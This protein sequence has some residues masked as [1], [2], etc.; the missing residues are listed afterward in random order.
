MAKSELQGNEADQIAVV[1]DFNRFYTARLGLLRKR[2]LDGE[3]SLT[4]ARI[5]YEIGTTP[6]TTASAL[7]GTLG[8]DA[9]YIS[10][11][12]SQLTRRKLIRQSASSKDGRE[13]LLSLAPAGEAAVARLN[14]LSSRQ[15]RD[16]LASVAPEERTVLVNSLSKVRAILNHATSG[17]VEVVRV[18]TAGDDA[19]RL[20][21]EYYEAVSVIQRDSP[22]AIQKMITGAASGMWLAYLNGEPV[23]CVML[24]ALPSISR[25]GECKRLY[26]RPSA[27]GNQLA[28]KL[29]DAMEQYAR[30][31][32]LHWIY[33]DSYED[34]K[35]AISLYRKRGYV[36]CE[37]YNDNPQAT[38]FLRKDLRSR[39]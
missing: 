8:L 14:E 37:R 30:E 22:Q 3:F 38:V 31:Q 11:L 16:L 36:P 12:L 35:A 23:G 15:I 7:R 34:L 29:L 25:A 2:H 19:L 10:R 4:E 6:K 17:A 21:R 5:L 24:K 1:R 39:S 13:R 28:A 18:S 26:V 33:L 32:G 9:G 20:L 27:R